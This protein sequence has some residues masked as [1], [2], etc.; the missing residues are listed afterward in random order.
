MR[1]RGPV[2]LV[3]ALVAGAL[4]LAASPPS[5]AATPCT[6][7]TRTTVATGLG[8]LENLLPDGTGGMLV[9]A[10][11]EIDRVTPDGTA[12]KVADLASP[13][14]LLP[15]HGKVLAVYGDDLQSGAL[16]KADGGLAIVDPVTGRVTP[17]AAGLTMPNGMALGPDDDAYVTRDLG[18]GTGI[19]RISARAPHTPQLRWADLDD[20]NGAVVDPTGSYLYVDQTFT[21]DSAVY[22]IPLADPSHLTAIAHLAG[23]GT[24]VPL[25]LDAMT[26]D[27]AGTLYLAANSGGEVIRLDPSTGA[28]CVLTTGLITPSSVRFGGGPGWPATTLYVVGFDGTLSALTPPPGQ[29]P[30]VDQPAPASLT[31]HAAIRAS[32]SDTGNGPHPGAVLPVPQCFRAHHPVRRGT[33]GRWGDRACGGRNAHGAHRA[34]REGATQH[35]RSRPRPLHGDPHRACPRWRAGA[36]DRE[37]DGG[38]PRPLTAG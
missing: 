10:G 25:G 24:A 34:H 35:P 37:R 6:A 27:A 30:P 1:R 7:W 32:L 36:C 22:R 14:Q 3:S 13:G 23:T 15:F 8:V 5:A 17:Y 2:A 31:L 20:T 38:P 16:D 21:A 29:I 33:R 28:T 4:P 18:S 12:T 26:R 9:S 11:S 19:T